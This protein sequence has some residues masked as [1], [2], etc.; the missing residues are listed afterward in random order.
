MT[1]SLLL[2]L[3]DTLITNRANSFVL[4][5][6][7]ALGKH[8]MSRF[9]PDHLVK[10][11]MI[12]TQMVIENDRPDRTLEEVFDQAFYPSL[13]V[14][15]SD[16]QEAIDIFYAQVFPTLQSLTAPRPEA[17]RLV[18]TAFNRGYQVAVATNPL[19]PR[20]AVYQR[21]GWAGL[22]PTAIHSS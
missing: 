21:L 16:L 22:P 9:N 18:E 2:D 1:L 4:A 13:S 7:R 8:L 5:Y 17:V 3:D 19:F 12:A 15:R 14:S 20:T 10:K 11:L 6:V